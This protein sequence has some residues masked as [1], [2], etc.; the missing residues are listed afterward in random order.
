MSVFTV[1]CCCCCFFIYPELCCWKPLCFSEQIPPVDKYSS[2]L[3][4]QMHCM[5]HSSVSY[6]SANWLSVVCPVGCVTLLQYV[7]SSYP[8]LHP[9]H[10][11]L[12][13]SRQIK[14][15][16]LILLKYSLGNHWSRVVRKSLFTRKNN[17]RQA[18][19]HFKRLAGEKGYQPESRKCLLHTLSQRFFA[20]SFSFV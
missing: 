10:S 4:R 17:N 20:F 14:R 1:F 16:F 19:S 9:R 15:W 2:I 3:S 6:I 7:T 5:V 13:T 12:Y 18:V 11:L 8:R